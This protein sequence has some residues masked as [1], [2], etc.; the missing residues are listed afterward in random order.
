MIE[1]PRIKVAFV[2]FFLSIRLIGPIENIFL[3]IFPINLKE[4]I[5]YFLE[6]LNKSTT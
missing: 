4:K 5:D 2:H 1:K 3:S 6:N